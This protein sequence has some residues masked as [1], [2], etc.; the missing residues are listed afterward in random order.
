MKMIYPIQDIVDDETHYGQEVTIRC[1]VVGGPRRGQQGGDKTLYPVR[2]SGQFEGDAF[3]S[4]WH[5]DPAWTDSF[6]RTASYLR[7]II[8]E[9]PLQQDESVVV[10]GIPNTHNGKWYFNVTGIIIRD[11]DTA[12]GKSEMRSASE[13]PRIYDLLYEKSV[14]SPGRYDLSPGAI[15]GRIVHTLVEHAIEE[16]GKAQF[17]GGWSEAQVEASLEELIESEYSIEMALCRLAWVSPNRIR[18]NALD[19]ATRLL[20]D[21]EF[22]NRIASATDVS[23]EVGLSASVGF[24]G[25]VDL[26]IDGAPYDLKTNYKL[27]DKTRNHHRFQLRVYLLALLLETLETGERLHDRIDKGVS[28]YLVYPNLANESSVVLEEV[29]LRRRDV[30]DILSLRNEASVLR[31]G[32]GVPTTYGRDC[33]GC[34]FKSPTTDQEKNEILPSPC[35]YY[36]QSER[37][38]PCFESDDEGNIIS[39]CPL[40]DDCDQRLEFR[41]PAV[42]DHY[43][44]LRQGLNTE[45]DHRKR[46]GYELEQLAPETLSEAGLRIPDLKLNALE[47][48]RRMVFTSDAGLV[49]SFTP[50]SGVRLMQT[51]TEYYQEATYY[52]RVENKYVFQLNSTPNSAFLNP[53]ETYEAVRTVAADSLPR[54][55][56]SQ[57][58]YAQRGEVSPLLETTGKAGDN[59]DSLD[60]SDLNSLSEYTDAKELYLDVPVRR[61]R[62]TLVTDIVSKLATQQYPSPAGGEEIPDDEQRA[63]ILCT[64]PE[65]TDSVEERLSSV[66]GATRMDG[67]AGGATTG[68][69]GTS[70]GHEIYEGLRDASV[71][72]SSARYA[73]SEQVF[74]AMR[75]GDESVRPHTDKFFDTIVIVGAESLAEPQFHFLQILGDRVAAIGDTRRSGP[76]IVSGEAREARLDEA[77]FNRLYR[78]FANVESDDSQ[79]IQVKAELTRTMQSAFSGL[80]LDAET[81]D[82]SFEFRDTD[83]AIATAIGETSLEYQVPTSTEEDET[84]FIRLEPVEQVDAVHISQSL[85]QL[86]TLDASALTFGETYTIQDIRFKVRTSNPIDSDHHRLK[87]SIPVHA[88]PYLHQRLTQNKAEAEKVAEVCTN[89]SPDLVVTPFVAHANAI[90][91]ELEEIGEDIAV[92]LPDQLSGAHVDSAVV[93]LAVTGEERVVTPPVSDI[94]QLYTCFNCAQDVT[95]VGDRETLER[96]SLISQLIEST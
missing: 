86:R 93:S 19:A 48:Q 83:G 85:Q 18:E 9:V 80:E 37:R 78:R 32:F 74:H 5:E 16:E 71:V 72:V 4:I 8:D 20:T 17:K 49:P 90:R 10:R 39:Q 59:E 75:D 45:R 92:R 94:E 15:K 29:E 51:G 67:F 23:V 84:R 87:V 55:L 12:I 43:T 81:I 14:Y 60:P 58:D 96:N 65:M 33:T 1:T 68:L 47:G 38:W 26:I 41:D 63:L 52:G 35:Q 42:T 69:T 28:G 7:E 3:L 62:T 22:T 57:L 31:D 34:T 88:T 27:T 54:E 21:D 77:Y 46:L 40:F 6:G 24:N 30:E 95:L 66:E 50:G 11:P 76:E 79:S 2:V 64:R 70:A 13:C 53:T 73:L 82:G 61:E 56:L 44:G 89:V 36:C 25:R 91:E